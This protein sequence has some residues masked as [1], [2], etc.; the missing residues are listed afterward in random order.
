[1]IAALIAKIALRAGLPNWLVQAI[2]ILLL[3]LTLFGGV[4]WVHHH[5]YHQGELAA[6]ARN[7]AVNK[8][9]SDRAKAELDRLNTQIAATQ[10]KLD[11][12]R[13]D[14][15]RLSKE[16]KDE[17]SVSTDRQRRLLAGTE[18]MS[19][20]TRQRPADPNGQAPGGSAAG[21]DQGTAVTQTLD[22]RVASDL[23]WAR[24]TRDEAIDRL[25]ACISSFDEVKAAADAMP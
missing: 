22:G 20:L 2:G 16:L 23:E 24:Q 19:I 1:M 11:M 9:N 14:V 25:N 7:T 5:I 8:A 18:R 10:A 3:C 4:A 21:L 12:A 13:A 15:T 17:K 6:D